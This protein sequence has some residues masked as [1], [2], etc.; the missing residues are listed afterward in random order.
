MAQSATVYTF[1][2]SLNDAD[3]GVYE[4]LEFRVARHPSESEEYLLT[5][6]LAYCLE[7]TEGL[8]F[9]KGLSEPDVPALLITD[10]T[11]LTR[12]WIEIGLPEPARL[13]TAAK[14]TPRVVVYAH[15][16]VS[17]W[18]ARLSQA[19]IHRLDHIEIFA[20]DREFLASLAQQLARRMTFDLT[21]S[22]GMLFVTLG[23][24]SLSG[25]VT[26][27]QVVRSGAR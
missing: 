20:I 7:Y 3:R 22:E 8:A 15:K 2:I 10:L 1:E 19:T 4:A 21:V 14:A 27:Q 13:H 5:R 6:V 16:E 24:L 23:A 26:R 17:A 25:A 11:G 18:L 9:S 12:G